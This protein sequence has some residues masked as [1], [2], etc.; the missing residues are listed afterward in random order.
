VRVQSLHIYPVKSLKGLDV[1][2]LNVR[3]DGP[4]GDRSFVITDPDG[5]FLTQRQIPAMARILTVRE[6][7]DLLLFS[8]D[9][10]I[11]VK[12]ALASAEKMSVHVWRDEVQ[13]QSL[14]PAADE[15][16]TE[17]LGRPAKIFEAQKNS[18]R[19]RQTPRG[20]DYELHF[21]D[22]A[23][24]LLTTTASLVELNRNLKTPITMDRFRP[25]VV[26]EGA[27]APWIEESWKKLRI[28]TVEFEFM[29]R[30]TRCKIITIDQTKGEVM[31]AEPL[32]ILKST[33]KPEQNN[34]DFGVHLRVLV[35]GVI[36]SGDALVLV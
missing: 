25:N 9:K 6:G 11:R 21:A 7:D 1:T 29:K 4:E 20:E 27:E 22:Q 5:K 35:P 2:E 24:L 12:T 19:V 16:V 23:Q 18:P 32:E 10:K 26:I 30:C 34:P 8:G 15:F 33:L 31:S 13:A 28:G 14:G 3:D 17:I 36:R